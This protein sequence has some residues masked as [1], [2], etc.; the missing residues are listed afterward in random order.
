MA[1]LKDIIA[2]R[3]ELMKAW[4]TNYTDAMAEAY[5][6]HTQVNASQAPT[7][8]TQ[9]TD[10]IGDFSKIK[11]REPVAP[12]Q[13]TDWIGD[14][15]K[16]KKREPV[17]PTQQTD[18][19]GDFSQI[20]KRPLNVND[21]PSQLTPEDQAKIDKMQAEWKF[22]QQSVETQPLQV[23][24]TEFKPV[25]Q[26]AKA[27]WIPWEAPVVNRQQEIQNNLATGYQTNPGLFTDRAAYDKA[28]NYATKSPEEQATLDS[29]YNSKQPTISSMYSA[30]I[31]KQE[32][33]DST[34]MTPAYKIAQNR[35]SKASSFSSMTPSQLSDQMRSA[36]LVE[37]SQ[38][39]EDLKA[40]NPKLVQ[41]AINLRKVNGDT[42]NI[43]TTNP[44]G[45]KVNNLENS[46]ADDYTD[47]FGE[48]I[49]TMYKVYTPAEITAII[50]TPDVVAAEDKAFA[51]EEKINELDKQIANIDSEV[52][53]E[54][55][56]SGATGSRLAMEKAA[57]RDVL[58][59]DRDS[60]VREYTTYA[61]RASNLITQNTTS[62]QTQQQ[63]QQA[64]N[65]AMLPFIQ[66]QYKTAQ[67]K[68]QAEFEL[69]DPATAIKAVMDEYKKL[70][71]PFTSTVQSRLAEFK[72]SGK[73]LE[74][75]LTEMWENIQQSPAYKKY[76]E[77]QQG[78]MSDTA[79]MEAQ[80]DFDIQKIKLQDSM[81]DRNIQRVGGT[82][83]N[84]I[85]GY[86]DGNKVVTVSVPWSTTTGTTPT[87]NIVPVTAGNK[88]VRLDQVWA[89]WFESAIGQLTAAWIPIVVW[90]GARDQT[91]TI[92][93]MANQYGIPFNASNPAE[94]AQK[95]RS[96]WHQVADPG[97]S[98][99]ETGMAI[100][101][102]GSSKLDK[103]TPAQEKI[104]NANGW[105]S[106]NISGDAGH[107]EY[108]GN[109]FWG[110]GTNSVD[111]EATLE[112]IRRGQVTDSDLGKIQQKA[113]S[114]WWW[115]DFTEALKKWMKS[116]MTESQIKWL[117][118]VDDKIQKD[119][120]LDNVNLVSQQKE[121][122]KWLLNTDINANWFND[123]ALINAFQ[124]IVDP[125][126]SVKEGDVS[127]LQS[128]IALKDKL[129]PSNLISKVNAGT[130][131]TPETRKQMLDSTVAI[132][133]A[134]ADFWNDLLQKRYYKLAD[135]Y[136]I[137]L[138]DYGYG[139]DKI[140]KAWKTSSSKLSSVMS[141]LEKIIANA[142]K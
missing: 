90:Q 70:G 114:G 141:I 30:I 137:N 111:K 21:L 37:G 7:A 99:H 4:N 102:Y 122:I 40:I 10:W 25:D 74:Q 73:P 46:I 49:K 59:K 52:D 105:Y 100:D 14:F 8:P 96:A 11:K 67:A 126:V 97:K 101:V 120:T 140:D 13:Q 65:A 95:L 72:A 133:N 57:R 34:K 53:T 89:T 36:K 27:K 29:F 33:P 31:N 2:K 32:V 112:R 77:L 117:A 108:R 142:P 17:A 127:L 136:G 109:W 18:W 128:S 63:Q 88:T 138:A 118:T 124:K 56:W 129:N 9:Q 15:S 85:Y 26:T 139:Y 58:N 12:T 19:M 79:K 50:R 103:V 55:K 20:K 84:P 62:F 83:D 48:F 92:Q 42:T 116:S 1:D 106:A 64:Q 87:G 5:A 41:D 44:D 78:Q 51:I 113:I 115:A 22:W 93:S 35:Y 69:N 104:L 119:T 131:L 110:S 71:I 68:K 123:I 39:F 45:T 94:T 54:F 66:D 60:Q 81:K 134:Q 75:F 28:Y 47:N 132:Y 23:W 3:E 98:N 43:W 121:T 80:Q 125:W 86:I 16:I 24:Q 76:Q 107:F 38:A 91:A 61:N 135:N 130:K 6:T 82:N